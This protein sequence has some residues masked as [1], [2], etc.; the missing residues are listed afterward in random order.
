MPSK[1]KP[2]WWR[3]WHRLRHYEKIIC[4]P[5]RTKT[6]AQ[7]KIRITT[8]KHYHKMKVRIL[9]QRPLMSINNV[10][11]P[12][13]SHMSLVCFMLCH[14]FLCHL[15]LLLGTPHK[16]T[17]HV[18]WASFNFVLVQNLSWWWGPKST[19]RNFTDLKQVEVRRVEA[20][21]KRSLA[22]LEFFNS[23]I[24]LSSFQS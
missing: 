16:C 13:N 22:H 19:R 10:G 6:L 8:Q 20:S 5:W 1:W 4:H 12:N 7:M 9:A 14:L 2:K 3:G 23:S 15:Y 18:Q 17:V 21:L 11:R 24:N